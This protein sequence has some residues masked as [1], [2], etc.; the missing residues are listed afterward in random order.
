MTD[1][2]AP[3]LK[4]APALSAPVASPRRMKTARTVLALML[5]E[6]Q[7]TY[8]RNV[9][10]YVW[11]FVEPIGGIALFTIVISIGLKIRDPSLGNSFPLFYASGF[12]PLTMF[13][14]V[15]NKTASALQ[16]S[17]SLLNYPG[18][19]FS[20]ALIARFLLT[21]LTQLL[22]SILILIGIHLIFEV[23]SILDVYQLLA[24]LTLAA[25]VGFGVG[26][27]NC[28]L[29]SVQPLWES[30]WSILTRPLFLFSTIFMTYEDVS[31]D[32]QSILW[33]NPVVHCVGLMRR[34][35]YATYDATWISVLF[36]SLL[37]MVTFGLGL[38]L[39]QR[40]HSD[41]LNR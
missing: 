8:G 33:W 25:F 13:L 26:A 19:R 39:L 36:L 30:F 3:P 6:M 37:S 40:Y 1:L 9:G 17:R 24:G 7:T 23:Q 18:V 4:I 21:T 27:I 29:F 11:A 16:F 22:V 28:F 5:R 10:G 20:D 2:T 15:S 35:L 14:T 38:T 12:L 41:I 32:F 31:R 34:G